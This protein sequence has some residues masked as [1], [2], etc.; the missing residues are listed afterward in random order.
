MV[1]IENVVG[2]RHKFS[3]QDNLTVFEQLVIALRETSPGYVVQAVQVDASHYGAPQHRPRLMIIGV[4]NDVA[5]NKKWAST[6]NLWISDFAENLKQEL[7]DLA[8]IPLAKAESERTVGHA[9]SD[10]L[11][12]KIGNL[13]IQTRLLKEQQDPSIWGLTKATGGSL[14]NQNPRSHSSETRL[15]FGLYQYLADSK[16]N[17]RILGLPTRESGSELKEMILK[18]IAT[19]KYPARNRLGEVLA[20]NETELIELIIRLKTKKHSQRVLELSQPARTVV[21]IGDDYVHPVEPRVF[22]VRELA[23]FQGFPNDFVFKAKETTGG[24][25]RKTDV[26]QYSQVGNAVSPY[27]AFAVGELVARVTGKGNA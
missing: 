6:E 22:T 14:A 7:P 16:V 9:L 27:M 20:N 18:E 25:S 2:M 21:T 12:K 13:W 24:Q 8:P 15:R 3:D 10:L 11:P 17:A 1:V 19:C 23:R 5:N 26:P 4:R